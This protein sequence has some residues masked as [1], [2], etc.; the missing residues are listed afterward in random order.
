MDTLRLHPD[1]IEQVRQAL[2][3][4]DIVSEHVVLRKRGRDFVGCCPFHD[5]KTPSFSVSPA[6]QFY[7]CFG[8]GAGGNGIKF[9]MELGKQ[10]F[11]EVVLDL[12]QRYQVPV[13]TLDHPRKQELQRQLSLREQLYEVLALACSFYQHALRQPQG[14]VALDYLRQVRQ[15]SEATIQEFQ[16]GYAP[17]GWQ[18]LYGYLVEQK[19]FP[20]ELIEQAGL[21]SPRK[22]GNGYLDRF[23]DRL[24][25]PIHDLQ[26]RVVGFGSRTLTNE[27]PKYLNSPETEVF[28]KG[29]LLFALDKAR[30]A[31]AR[32]DQAIVVEGYFDAIALHAA[33]I[34]QAV[35]SMGTA[36]SRDQIRQ[37]LR[38]S[39]SK[40][41]LLNFD[42]DA[43]GNRAAERAI[44]EIEDLA[45][46]GE[47]QLRVLNLPNG[48]DADEFLRDRS[49][50]E[51]RQ[52][53]QAAPQWVDWQISKILEAKDPRRA[54]HLQEITQKIVQLI[55]KIPN[56]VGR[57]HYIRHCAELLRESDAQRTTELEKALL[58]R[59]RGQRWH[60]RSQ[61]WQRPADFTLREAAEAQLLRI[62]LHCPPYRR[63][64]QDVLKQRD[65]EFS[66][67]H[68]RF[69]WR[70]IIAIEDQ[71]IAQPGIAAPDS[72]GEKYQP[73]PP[74]YPHPELAP[75]LDLITALQDLCTEYPQELQ[76][77]YPLIQLSEKTQL[78]I[79]RPQLS[80]QAA[81]ASLERI[82]CE[83][84]CR[85]LLELW[86]E[87]SCTATQEH[88]GKQML[89]SYLRQIL[90]AEVE[91]VE[92]LLAEE[93]YCFQEL[94]RIRKLYYQEKQYLQ[95]LDQQRCTSLKQLTQAQILTPEDL[96]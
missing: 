64:I 82:A 10:S 83:K 22:S 49:P 68:H 46:R 54:D 18:V 24:M 80:I 36:L 84:R 53:L 35:A 44:G 86:Q 92:E 6:K 60:G 52:I 94:E 34:N 3:I 76:A 16:L 32:Q 19:R 45:L 51:F 42:A 74:P 9:L 79:L 2:D 57:N 69:L 93:N 12:A 90:D 56:A 59:V 15:L 65:L 72:Y 55:A 77:V 21:I 33:G 30:S 47:V 75:D 25:I 31:I 29:K 38:Y 11:T 85:H 89:S 37:L 43:A 20:G 1:T 41:I 27:Q 40:Q 5:D 50:E 39:E 66:L 14:Q 26:G 62:Y 95:Q 78:D 23:R 87:T 61:K 17:A 13:Q 96:N 70:E 28:N 88:Q 67:S 63:Q 81:A 4:V 58:D 8:C 48:K 71:A 7:Y 91:Q 73:A